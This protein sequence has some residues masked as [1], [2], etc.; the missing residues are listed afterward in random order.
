MRRAHPSISSHLTSSLLFFSLL[1]NSGEWLLVFAIV[2]WSVCTGLIPAVADAGI[3]GLIALRVLLGVAEGLALPAVHS[4]LSVY[5]PKHQQSTSASVITAACYIGT[6]LSNL[7][8]PVLIERSGWESSFYTFAT[9]PFLWVPMWIYYIS[10]N[11]SSSNVTTHTSISRL[12]LKG[13][14]AKDDDEMSIKELL[15]MNPVWAIMLA[16]YGQ[17]VGSIGLLSWLPTYYSQHFNVPLSNLASFTVLP[18]F[19]QMF[20]AVSAGRLADYMIVNNV[21]GNKLNVRN[22]FQ[23][24]GSFLPAFFLLT[25]VYGS[26]I[27]EHSSAIDVESTERLVTLGS[28]CTALTVASVSCYQFDISP[29]NAGTIFGL[30]NTASC[31]GGLLAVPVTGYIYDTTGSWDLVF[32]LFAFHY[33]VFGGFAWLSLTSKDDAFFE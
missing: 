12:T 8:T 11:K 10:L 20:I 26:P 22:L 17:G 6:L 19:L 23:M 14:D 7:I 15:S 5:I 25:C 3:S 29:R 30:G 32:A 18:Y 31:I 4:M 13:L 33:V 28:A 16:Q 9:L 21:L 27:I 2:A 24:G 1:S